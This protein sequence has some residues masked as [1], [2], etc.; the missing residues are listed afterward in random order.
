M[1]KWIVSYLCVISFCSCSHDKVSY[2]YTLQ[3]AN[4]FLRYELDADVKM[5]LLI[6]TCKGENDYLYFQNFSSSE[7]LIY[8][9]PR[10]SL[11]KRNRFEEEGANAIRGGFLRGFM[12]TDCDRIFISGLA[13]GCIYETDTAGYIKNEM[14]F[15]KSQ[16][17]YCPLVCA[18][19]NGKMELIDGKLYLPQNLNWQ[20]GDKVMESPLMC[21]VD[22]ETGNARPLPIYFP[23]QLKDER[24]LRGEPTSVVAKY[25]YCFD[26]NRF[27]YSF[28]Y[29]DELM[30][31]DSQ[32]FEVSYKAGKSQYIGNV[33]VPT[34]RNKDMVNVNR[35]LLESPAYDKILYDNE[36]E[37]FYRIVYVPQN[38]EKN[39]DMISLIRSGR[40]Q[41]SIMMYDKNF[42]VIGEDLFPEYTY[43][44]KLSFV[45]QGS[46][47]I[48]TNHVMS[49]DYSDDILSFQK[50]DL[51]KL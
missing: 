47:Y 11:V 29:S 21:C 10:G 20:L 45:Y 27:V 12:M 15:S 43:N 30:V 17:G 14:R 19:D 18:D 40:K 35:I 24:V 31:V 37:V 42:N 46:L 16:N 5:P 28:A 8:D 44:P 41:F 50:M 32:T 9:I 2:S 49:P 34:F 4:V 7:L 33:G 38:I 22:M 26:G 23:Q 13:D 48:S 3:P 1:K 36:N 39:T 51:V 25:K 6:Y